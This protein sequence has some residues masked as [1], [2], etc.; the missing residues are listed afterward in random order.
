MALISL[1]PLDSATACLSSFMEKRGVSATNPMT[2]ADVSRA[3]RLI[4]F[5]REHVSNSIPTMMWK[6][7]LDFNV[8]QRYGV[9]TTFSRH[10]QHI[11]RVVHGQTNGRLM[12]LVHSSNWGK[13]SSL[14]C[15][16]ELLLRM[17]NFYFSLSPRE[18]PPSLFPEQCE[19]HSSSM[20]LRSFVAE[21]KAAEVQWNILGRS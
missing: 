16:L 15:T 21:N 7:V 4:V 11:E 19:S 5:I 2:F 18:I 9:S 20:K 14:F 17:S 10:N 13:S 8:Y 3:C 12:L 1:G 6:I